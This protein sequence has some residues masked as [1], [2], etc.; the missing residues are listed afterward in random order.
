[1]RGWRREETGEK[2]DPK[3]EDD[4]T[5]GGEKKKGNEKREQQRYEEMEGS[6]QIEHSTETTDF[7]FSDLLI[8]CDRSKA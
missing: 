7:S 1:M 5:G 8:C 3:G 2:E 4:E 6:C